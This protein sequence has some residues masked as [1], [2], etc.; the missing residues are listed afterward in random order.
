MKS[1]DKYNLVEYMDISAL[2]K[3]LKNEE[4]N[5]YSNNLIFDVAK[6]NDTQF[7]LLIPKFEKISVTLA[8]LDKTFVIVHP[9]LPTDKW[10]EFILIPTINEAIEYIYMDELTREF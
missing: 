6:V 3:I 8:N 1:F 9:S 4:N 5:L 10:E 7:N 2:D